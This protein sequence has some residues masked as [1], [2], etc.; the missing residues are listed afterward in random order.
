MIKSRN[1]Y[2]EQL[3]EIKPK[4]NICLVGELDKPMNLVTRAN[5]SNL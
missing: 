3:K 4:K 2:Q 1:N 5:T